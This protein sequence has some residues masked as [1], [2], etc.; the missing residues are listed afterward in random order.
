MVLCIWVLGGIDDLARGS[1]NLC[2]SGLLLVGLV[3]SAFP[4]PGELNIFRKHWN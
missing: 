4:L 3:F 1:F 2:T